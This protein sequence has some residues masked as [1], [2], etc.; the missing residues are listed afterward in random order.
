MTDDNLNKAKELIYK[1]SLQDNFLLDIQRIRGRFGI[2]PSEENREEPPSWL[3]KNNTLQYIE[4]KLL[5][6]EKYK[7]PQAYQVAVD[8][9]IRFNSV[10][11][12]SKPSV[13][14]IDRYAHENWNGNIEE[15][16]K[17][18]KEPFVKI[19][20][21]NADN[22]KDLHKFIDDKFD[23][24]QEIF[25]EQGRESQRVRSKSEKN[26]EIDKLII[27][28]SK[29]STPQLK[30]LLGITKGTF[31]KDDLIKKILSDR[32]YKVSDLYVR[33]IIQKHRQ[34]LYL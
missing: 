31:Y 1:L 34:K 8:Q 10:S 29:H 24:I 30:S 3:T 25:S 13:A 7:I 16:Y 18:R 20:I 6:L 11:S 17:T 5:I 21:L 33:K 9:F 15:W 32:G 27:R 22:K 4:S 23:Q 28:Y 14:F 19:I 12:Q 26:K 2:T